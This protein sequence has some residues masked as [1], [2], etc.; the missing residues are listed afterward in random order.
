MNEFDN[1][2]SLEHFIAG[3]NLS[4]ESNIANSL[5]EESI[6]QEIQIGPNLTTHHDPE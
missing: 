3:M 2:G 1:P 5:K 6:R 4:N